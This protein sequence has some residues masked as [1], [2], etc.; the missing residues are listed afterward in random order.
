MGTPTGETL[1]TR[2]KETIDADVEALELEPVPSVYELFAADA[3]VEAVAGET[4]VTK[5]IETIDEEPNDHS[6]WI[7]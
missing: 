1:N 4:T 7:I 6:N 2:R 5:K 3:P